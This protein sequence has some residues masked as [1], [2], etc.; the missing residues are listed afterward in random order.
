MATGKRQQT[1]ATVLALLVITEIIL[2]FCFK[3]IDEYLFSEL[4]ITTEIAIISAILLLVVLFFREE[5]LLGLGGGKVKVSINKLKPKPPMGKTNFVEGAIGYVLYIIGSAVAFGVVIIQ[6][7]LIQ[8][9]SNLLIILGAV[10]VFASGKP[11]MHPVY[12]HKEEVILTGV[13]I[14]VPLMYAGVIP[15]FIG[16]Q[17]Y[18]TTDLTKLLVLMGCCGCLYFS[19]KY[20]W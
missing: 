16:L 10:L 6:M 17:N 5:L 11:F 18:I 4:Q 12:I 15:D 14:V 20:D 1:I 9:V 13:A 3:V 2:H 19:A 7:Q 8:G